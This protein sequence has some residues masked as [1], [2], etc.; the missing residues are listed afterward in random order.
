MILDFPCSFAPVDHQISG[1][2]RKRE[3]KKDDKKS[4]AKSEPLKRSQDEEDHGVSQAVF[5]LKVQ[6]QSLRPKDVS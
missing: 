1:E 5:S 2:K 4:R 6:D 3:Q